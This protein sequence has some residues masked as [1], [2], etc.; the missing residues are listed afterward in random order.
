MILPLKYQHLGSNAHFT[1][2]FGFDVGYELKKKL[3]N[4]KK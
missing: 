2:W 1:Y 4:W 3:D